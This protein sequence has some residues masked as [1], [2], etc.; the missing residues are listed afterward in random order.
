MFMCQTVSTP[1][2]AA[3]RRCYFSRASVFMKSICL[4]IVIHVLPSY[5]CVCTCEYRHT[6]KQICSETHKRI[7]LYVC[8]CVNT[9]MDICVYVHIHGIDVESFNHGGTCREGGGRGHHVSWQ[10]ASLRLCTDGAKTAC[11]P[12][13]VAVLLLTTQEVAF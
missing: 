9:Y 7:R 3:T 8:M 13:G 4:Y 5:T 2:R 12:S 1:A 10:V 11:H 6:Y